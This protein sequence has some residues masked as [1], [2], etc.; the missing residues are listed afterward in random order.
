MKL[1]NI[2]W[3]NQSNALAL[4]IDVADL[5]LTVYRQ[6]LPASVMDILIA[7]FKVNRGDLTDLVAEGTRREAEVVAA[8]VV[9]GSPEWFQAAWDVAANA[10]E[11]YQACE[12]AYPYD[13]P[14]NAVFAVISTVG[15]LR[16]FPGRKPGAIATRIRW[17]YD[18]SRRA[19]LDQAVVARLELKHRVNDLAGSRTVSDEQRLAFEAAWIAGHRKLAVQIL[20]RE[21]C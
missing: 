21:D 3:R 12:A 17:L 6:Q 8:G 2:A 18:D 9:K 1:T 7:R 14:R 4:A 20:K 11:Q 13:D 5:A 10:Q 19:K 15:F 16:H